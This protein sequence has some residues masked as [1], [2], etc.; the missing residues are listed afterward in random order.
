MAFRTTSNWRS[1]LMRLGGSR[2]FASSTIPK[3]RQ[4]APTVDAA[5]ASNLGSRIALKGE[6]A[7]IYMVLG[8]VLLAVTIGT[9]TAKQQLMHSPTVYLNKKRRESIPEVEDPDR[10][11]SSA[12]KF[13]NNSF[14]RKL[15]HIQD[16]T[17]TLPDPSRPDPYTR[18]RNAETLKSAGVDPAGH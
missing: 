8:M 7:P 4:F 14:L 3:M 16:N 10:V 9:H 1:M 17:R 13:V 5:R 11:I 18:S 2:S 6:F 12:D 15:A